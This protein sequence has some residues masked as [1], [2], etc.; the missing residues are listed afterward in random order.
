[1]TAFAPPRTE[2]GLPPFY[3]I[4]EITGR[5][6]KVLC[7]L[8]AGERTIREL[9]AATEITSTDR[10]NYQLH[11]LETWGLVVLGDRSGRCRAHRSVRPNY[12]RLVYITEGGVMRVYE[13]TLMMRSGERRR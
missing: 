1:M 3:A 5:A 8:H 10:V 13:R 9:V 4:T 7:A 11:R 6:G 2:T 12:P